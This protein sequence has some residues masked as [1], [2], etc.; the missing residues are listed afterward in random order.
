MNCEQTI[1]HIEALSVHSINNP[2]RTEYSDHIKKC[3]SCQKSYLEQKAYLAQ[4]QNMK[5]PDLSP[6]SASVLLRNV[7]NKTDGNNSKPARSSFMQGFIAASVLALS[8]FGVWSTSQFQNNEQEVVALP[9]FITTEVVLV[10]NAPEDIY[11]ADLNLV[12][13]QQ[14]SLKGYEDMPELTWP[15]DLKQGVNTLSLPIRINADQQL[16][17]P[18]SIMAKLYHYTDEREFE[19]IVDLSKAQKNNQTLTNDNNNAV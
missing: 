19:I 10:I 15:V 12:L 16:T 4:M 2:L 5:T 1:N 18:F 14:V 17:K 13:P 3:E 11:D 7:R 9:R 8:V 6:S